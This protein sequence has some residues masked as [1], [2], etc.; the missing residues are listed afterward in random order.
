MKGKGFKYLGFA[1]IVILLNYI[2]TNFSSF[3]NSLSFLIGVIKPI[4]IGI[5]IAYFVYPLVM[6]LYKRFFKGY[7][8]K[9]V[10]H[11]G[12]YISIFLSYL[13]IFFVIYSLTYWVSPILI[14][15]LTKMAGLDLNSFYQSLNEFWDN[16]QANFPML[17]N[18][19]FAAV[20][21]N[22]FEKASDFFINGG[23][24]DYF[25]SLLGITSSLYAYVMGIIL[26][27]YMIVSKEEL[28]R[29]SNMFFEAI[30]SEKTF[31]IVKKYFFLFEETFRK[32]FFG[33]MLDS[34][35]I[36]VLAFIGLYLLK[37][38]FYPV[39]ALIVMVTNMIPYFGP[40]IGGI[41]VVTVT[42]FVT[43]SP[44]HAFWSG[45]FILALQ[46]FDGI[47]LGPKILGDS[48]GVS[49]VWILIAIIIGGALFKVIGLLLCVPIA[50]TFKEIFRE[51]YEYRMSQRNKVN[52]NTSE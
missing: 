17:A 14:D 13:F 11:L 6:L 34:F 21:Q 16:L 37:I 26:S 50:A 22:I 31:E 18:V 39:L 5:M 27:I 35:I 47:Y 36:G 19:E 40:F 4:I 46:Q 25:N 3:S 45:V 49:S 51:F 28:F 32:F 8:L 7:E 42:L 38:P 2:I 33:K 24:N 23:I 41:P 15:S 10:K 1:L 12:Y 9:Y 48:V 30:F 44:L 43:G 52:E 29:A 20:I